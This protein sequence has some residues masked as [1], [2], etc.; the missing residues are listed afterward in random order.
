[1]ELRV[2]AID[3]VRFLV[4]LDYDSDCDVSSRNSSE[5]TNTILNIIIPTSLDVDLFCRHLHIRRS[6]L[7]S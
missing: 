5:P 6:T 2:V 7:Q 1:M 3:K 4:A